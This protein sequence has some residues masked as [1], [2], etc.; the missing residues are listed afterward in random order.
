MNTVFIV[1]TGIGASIGG[2]AGD[3]TPAF[4]LIASISDIAIT[5]PNVVNASKA[6][7]HSNKE[8]NY[9]KAEEFG[10]DDNKEFMDNFIYS[11]Y[12]VELNMEVDVK[13][14]ETQI[15]G[16]AGVKLDKPVTA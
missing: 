3:A 9:D 11:L 6:Y 10:L 16:I 8:S 5:H 14:G 13:T 12:E 4:K 7:L 1:P 2:D 15:L